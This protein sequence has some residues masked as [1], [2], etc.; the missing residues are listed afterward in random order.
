MLRLTR[1]SLT[2]N[3]FKWTY[4]RKDNVPFECMIFIYVI[5][6]ATKTIY[7]NFNRYFKRISLL[8]LRINLSTLV[9]QA[10]SNNF[11]C[12]MWLPMSCVVRC[13][14]NF[15]CLVDS[16]LLNTT[17]LGVELPFYTYEFNLRSFTYNQ[18]ETLLSSN[19][20][21]LFRYLLDLYI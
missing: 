7:I 15:S 17:I 18:T 4:L 16:L 3:A 11:S 6:S 10:Q 19:A 2:R 5:G 14:F 9:F 1:R 13:K 21:D 12:D 8:L 20:S